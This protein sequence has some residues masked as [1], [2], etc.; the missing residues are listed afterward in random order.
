MQ[1]DDR[2]MDRRLIKLSESP[3]FRFWR[4]PDDQLTYPERVFG[5]IWELE[6]E[7][8]NGGFE[9][10]FS[11]ST[12]SLAPDVVNALTAVGADQMAAITQSAI[13]EVGEVQWSDD[14]ARKAAISH[15]SSTALKH[16]QCLDQA[17]YRYP[18]DLTELLYRYVHEHRDEITGSS[19]IF[20]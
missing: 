20:D 19:A 2:Q 3:E 7:V 10:Y 9:Q 16:L 11:N 15:L 18:D 17:F 4:V 8:N 6:S 1:P 12:G 14:A 5:L 13:D